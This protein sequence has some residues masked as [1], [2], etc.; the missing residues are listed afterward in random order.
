MNLAHFSQKKSGIWW[1]TT[2]TDDDW[3]IDLNLTVRLY[4]A[5]SVC[6]KFNDCPKKKLKTRIG[7]GWSSPHPSHTPIVI[8]WR[9]IILMLCILSGSHYITSMPSHELASTPAWLMLSW[10]WYKTFVRDGVRYLRG[11]RSC[12]SVC[13]NS[14]CLYRVDLLQ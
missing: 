10:N 6:S 3:L 14:C 5:N 12:Y 2:E 8:N 13:D 7:G 9:K 1:S 11:A 4:A